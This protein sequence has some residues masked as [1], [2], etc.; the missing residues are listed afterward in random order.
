MAIHKN[1]VPDIYERYATAFRFV[2]IGIQTDLDRRRF[3]GGGSRRANLRQPAGGVAGTCREKV[4][5]N[6]S[7]TEGKPVTIAGQRGP[8][9]EWLTSPDVS[10]PMAANGLPPRGGTGRLQMGKE[11]FARNAAGATPHYRS[12]PH[13]E[14]KAFVVSPAG[15]VPSGPYPQERTTA[16]EPQNPPELS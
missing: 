6:L 15:G 16:R 12:A 1:F 8:K 14:A 3:F 4:T 13:L 10:V 7:G 5:I 9:G 2:L 11:S